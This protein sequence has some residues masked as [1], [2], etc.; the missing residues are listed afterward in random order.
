M[1]C[2][3]VVKAS[4]LSLL[5]LI[6]TGCVSSHLSYSEDDVLNKSE[7][8]SSIG[9][10]QKFIFEKFGNPVSCEIING[11][12]YCIYAID[13]KEWEFNWMIPFAVIPSHADEYGMACYCLIFN[14]QKILVNVEHAFVSGKDEYPSNDVCYDKFD[15]IL[16]TP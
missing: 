5:I 7:F 8:E 10:N 14:G 1:K 15:V 6:L 13:I 12:E 3:L 9:K 11:S 4:V 2:L 16:T